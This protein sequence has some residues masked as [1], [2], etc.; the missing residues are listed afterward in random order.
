MP[1]N[2][3]VETRAL[4]RLCALVAGLVLLTACELAPIDLPV[5]LV[6]AEETTQFIAVPLHQAW[7]A[8][9]G[10]IFV[11]E[12]DLVN[13][14]EQRI[15][16]ANHTLAAGD[17]LLTLRART[18]GGRLVYDEFLRRVGGLP[19]PFTSLTPG[20]LLTGEDALGPYLW[21]EER[22]GESTICVLAFRRLDSG[23]RQMPGRSTVMDVMLR[24]CVN[25]DVEQALGPIMAASVGNHPVYSKT[26]AKGAVRMLSPL[27]GPTPQ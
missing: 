21:A 13:S 2:I 14:V 18:R 26:P 6:Q 12:R 10:A 1:R 20:D 4:Q 3:C 23:A 24:N 25:G 17:N 5:T 19:E 22:R 27:A 11:S 7:V 8:A 9:P 15:G 16:L